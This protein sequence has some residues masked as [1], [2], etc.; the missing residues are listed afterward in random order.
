MG[1]IGAFGLTE[2]LRPGFRI[3][4]AAIVSGTPS[5]R[6]CRRR[7]ATSP[8]RQI[9][10]HPGHQPERLPGGDGRHRRGAGPAAPRRRP[11]HC[12]DGPARG[13]SEHRV[14]AGRRFRRDAARPAHRGRRGGRLRDRLLQ[15]PGLHTAR[16]VADGRPVLGIAEWGL[17]GRSPSANASGSLPCRRQ[18]A[19][20]APDGPPDGLGERYA[21]S[22]PVEALA[23]ETAGE[24]I[25]YRLIAA[26]R[27]LVER[28][29]ADVL[30]L[31]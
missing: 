20:P 16:E 27:T 18:R 21:G 4:P 23:E 1:K 29:G 31:G 7:H 22:R 30:V 25:R 13:A 19:A 12:S 17:L 6:V 10:A 3:V 2:D 11:Q 28:D 26:A 9:R 5:R 8:R 24:A 14:P 15:R